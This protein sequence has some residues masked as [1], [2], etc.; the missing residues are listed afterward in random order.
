MPLSSSSPSSMIEAY[1]LVASQ[2]PQTLAHPVRHQHRHFSSSSSSGVGSSADGGNR[3]T[4]PFPSSSSLASMRSRAKLAVKRVHHSSSNG[5]NSSSR[6]SLAT[7]SGRSRHRRAYN[8]G[9][10]LPQCHHQPITSINT[11]CSGSTATTSV[12]A[13]AAVAAA[14][15][16]TL[17][18]L[19][20]SLAA[21]CRLSEFAGP[22]PATFL[23]LLLSAPAD[24]V[25]TR[26]DTVQLASAVSTMAHNGWT[27]MRLG[28]MLAALGDELR[29]H[30]AWRR[31]A[32]NTHTFVVLAVLRSQRTRFFP[33]AAASAAA[34]TTTNNSSLST[35]PISATCCDPWPQFA[36]DVLVALRGDI[37]CYS[38]KGHHDDKLPATATYCVRSLYRNDTCGPDIVA[39]VCESLPWSEVMRLCVA[40]T[41]SM[42]EANSFIQHANIMV[43]PARSIMLLSHLFAHGR[44]RAQPGV[45]GA[46][47]CACVE[48][49]LLGANSRTLDRA[50]GLKGLA[51]RV[52]QH[53]PKHERDALCASAQEYADALQE[54]AEGGEV[55]ELEFED[56]EGEGETEMTAVQGFGFALDDTFTVADVV[57]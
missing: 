11:V 33:T 24:K 35:P 48:A 8:L 42:Y 1:T 34:T 36:A 6:I 23:G 30:P 37:S 19:P 3:F 28:R 50:G 10:L 38:G 45:L 43:T 56:E 53:W 12:V 46:A 14:L 20:P 40:C 4:T 22:G 27:A 9:A 26:A 41:E 15:P 49:Q 16:T 17:S 55:Y 31:L 21:D 52:T 29:L 13:A 7:A 44:T 18:P 39:A 54:E 57:A 32:S 25:A 51:L 2:L 5:G 47:L